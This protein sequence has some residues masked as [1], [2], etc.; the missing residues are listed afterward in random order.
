[1][2]YQQNPRPYGGQRPPYQQPRDNRGP[3]NRN[4]N[5]GQRPP[6]QNQGRPQGQ[7]RQGG[8]N[9]RGYNQ[10]PPRP[11][12]DRPAGQRKKLP[13]TGNPKENYLRIKAGSSF[14]IKKGTVPTQV[15][16]IATDSYKELQFAMNEWLNEHAEDVNIIDIKYS[17][18][19]YYGCSCCIIYQN[20]SSDIEKTVTFQPNP[21]TPPVNPDG[22]ANAEGTSTETPQA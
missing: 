20:C 3:N 17:V 6:F 15:K 10:R 7:Q 1:M 19:A 21:V 14:T 12:G 11:Q 18:A 8:W 9:N 22:N 5:G 2:D 16:L 13:G 4:F